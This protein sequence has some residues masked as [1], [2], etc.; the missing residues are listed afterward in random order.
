VTGTFG[1]PIMWTETLHATLRGTRTGE[2]LRRLRA[3]A[4]AW[5]DR[6]VARVQRRR[7]GAFSPTAFERLVIFLVPERDI[8]NGGI[9]AIASNFRETRR[10][11]AADPSLGVFMCTMPAQRRLLGHTRF[12]N[13]HEIFEVR[14]VLDRFPHVHRLLVHVPEYV[15]CSLPYARTLTRRLRRPALSV[16][17]NILLQNIDLAPTA[18]EVRAIARIAPVTATAVQEQYSNEDTAR[19]LG[20]PVHRL[21][22]Y[23]S[24]EQYERRPLAAKQ[25]LMIV[26]PDRHPRRTQVLDVLRARLPWLRL[27]VV[28]HMTYEA[29]KALLL[30]AKWSLTFGEGLDSYF[31]E[32]VFSGGISFAAFNTRFFTPDFAGLETVYPTYDVMVERIAADV[33]GLGQARAYEAYQARQ[34]AVCARHCDYQAYVHNLASFY[35]RYAHL[36]A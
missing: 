23:V 30:E 28:E 18:D 17:L 36:D 3:L 16:R 31:L 34:F 21:S 14:D 6:R 32:T 2:V 5:P 24:P 26:S 35:D 11:F 27:H 29:Y 33:Q 15:V 20:C 22:G 12:A 25:D 9:L 10:L 4:Y 8:V 13:D 19:R 1:A 7:L